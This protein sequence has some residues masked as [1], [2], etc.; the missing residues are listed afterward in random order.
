M[1]HFWK[2]SVLF[3]TIGLVITGCSNSGGSDKGFGEATS[4]T[5]PG[6]VINGIRWATRNV[7]KPGT[8]AAKSEDT[9][10]FYKWNN[11]V[12]WTTNPL[13]NSNGNTEWDDTPLSVKWATKNDPS[14]K[15]WRLP[16]LEEIQS[17]ADTDSVLHESIT[18][19][20]VNGKK[21]TDKNTGAT[22][23]LPSAGFL[24]RGAAR[25]SLFG[26]NGQYWS[27]EFQDDTYPYV[28]TL[29]FYT[30]YGRHDSEGVVCY[31]MYSGDYGGSNLVIRS[32]AK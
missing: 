6:V 3:W 32:V 10:M 16:T 27:S 26:N 7:D 19:N 22:L 24:Q 25:P 5:D 12:G 13:T 23:F 29:N 31:R 28:V 21:I 14:P 8:F 17:L 4:T 1:K 15:G 20:G 18:Q 30:F 2:I 11:K 9:G